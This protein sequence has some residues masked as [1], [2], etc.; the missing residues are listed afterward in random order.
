MVANCVRTAVWQLDNRLIRQ[1][2]SWKELVIFH[3]THLFHSYLLY[4]LLPE[5]PQRQHFFIFH[6][7]YFSFLWHI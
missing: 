6:D 2:M 3:V 5:M 4:N 7:S 1:L